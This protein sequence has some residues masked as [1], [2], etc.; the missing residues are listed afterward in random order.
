MESPFGMGCR[1]L[2]ATGGI[3]GKLK[4]W[5]TFSG[6]CF[7]TFEQ[8]S[9]S[10]EDITFVPQGNAVLTASLDGTVCA[11]DLIRLRLFRIFKPDIIDVQF[12]CIAVDL[13]GQIVAAGSKGVDNSIYLWNI[14]VLNI[15]NVKISYLRLISTSYFI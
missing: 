6:F 9:S 3:D 7:C 5:D 2:I 4:L 15:L 14:Q 10:I 12:T 11:F 1:Y 8:H 13:S